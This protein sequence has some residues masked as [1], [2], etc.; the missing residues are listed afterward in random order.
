MEDVCSVMFVSTAS[1]LRMSFTPDCASIEEV[2]SPW[3]TPG[4][5]TMGAS[6]SSRW[7]VPMS[8]TTNTPYLPKWVWNEAFPVFASRRST[9]TKALL[10]GDGRHGLQHAQVSGRG[11][12]RQRKT[13][14]SP[15]NKN[16]RG[17]TF[18][19]LKSYTNHSFDFHSFF[20]LWFQVLHCP[21]DDIE[22]RETKKS[23]KEKEK[24]EGKKSQSKATK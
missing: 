14:E 3:P 19:I 21:F 10:A 13:F 9:Q 17:K 24:E 12:W 15:Q 11:M 23:K 4:H 22:P 1:T 7:D 8:S 2:W 20:L 18:R 5:T 6:S 16:G